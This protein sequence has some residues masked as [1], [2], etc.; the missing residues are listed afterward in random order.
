MKWCAGILAISLS[1]SACGG[2]PTAPSTTTVAGAWLAD[3]TLSSA[4]GGECLGG[5][6]QAAVGSR[7]VFMAALKQTGTGLEATITSQGNGTS[8]AYAGSASGGGSL[9]LTLSTCQA[10]RVSGVPCGAGVTRDLQLVGGTLTATVN[11]VMG[12]G[13]GTDVSTWNV[14]VPGV[15]APAGTLTLTA[16]F[17][18]VFLGV[19]PSDYHVFTGTIFPGYADGTIS[20]PADP[21]PF[22]VKCGWF[23]G[24]QLLEIR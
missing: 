10:S 15:A 18:W 1:L 24:P 16:G 19:P 20:I 23:F 17:T 21:N 6:M 11:T 22:C 13:N 8:C 4:S 9:S 5:A 14:V 7:D 2:S 3:S 12:T